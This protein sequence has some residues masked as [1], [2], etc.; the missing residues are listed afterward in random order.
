MP[1]LEDIATIEHIKEEYKKTFLL[2][3][4]QKLCV[5]MNKDAEYHK[6]VLTLYRQSVDVFKTT[7]IIVK[8][9]FNYDLT[10]EDSKTIHKWLSAYFKKTA[11][12][13]KIKEEIKTQ[14]YTEQNGRCIICGE[15]LGTEWSRI[16]VDHI[17]PWVLVGDELEDNYQ[18]LCDTCNQCKSSR[19]DYVFKSL[20]GLN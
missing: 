12:R 18:L 7:A 13:K 9:A 4:F 17:I 10:E 19:T 2:N 8:K 14:L 5:R 11:T 3:L 6:K 16:H 1:T 20:I 15:K